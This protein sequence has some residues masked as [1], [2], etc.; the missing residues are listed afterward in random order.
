MENKREAEER[1]E[2]ATTDQ[3]M[4]Q[5]QENEQEEHVVSLNKLQRT[6]SLAS[7][8]VMLVRAVRRRSLL[9]GIGAGYLI[10][11]GATGTCPVS[12]FIGQDIME[13]NPLRA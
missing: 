9:R 12:E 4:D 5:D 11:R 7:G 8:A 1:D 3:T 6:M 10:Y 13:L 2:L